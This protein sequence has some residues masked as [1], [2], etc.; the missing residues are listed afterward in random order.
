MEGKDK[1]ASPMAWV[2]GQTG[3]HKGQYVLSVVL[4]IV[5]VAFSVAPYFV[6]TGI[7]KG[8]ME[9]NRDI[10][11]Y[12]SKCLI[13]A[14]MWLIRVLFHSFSTATSHMATFAVLEIGRAHV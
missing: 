5:G 4:A 2:I 3:V 6:V 14:V 7:V 8:L 13:I 12:T 10:R 1:S 9:D 11:F